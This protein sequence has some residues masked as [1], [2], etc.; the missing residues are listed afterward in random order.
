MTA[1]ERM[2]VI[3]FAV[4]VFV[5][6]GGFLVHVMFYKPYSDL[7]NRIETDRAEISKRQNELQAEKAQVAR[8]LAVDPRM[9][10]WP[11]LS[12][13]ESPS[14]DPEQVVRIFEDNRLACDRDLDA[15]FK[16]CGFATWTTVGKQIEDKTIPQLANKVPVFKRH[17]FTVKAT[18][19]YK[20]IVKMFEQFYREE[21]L[22]HIRD[23]KITRPITTTQGRDR[24]ILDIT[25]TVE[26]LQVT[27]AETTEVRKTR[28]E[29]EKK[30]KDQL[31]A[32]NASA[33][34]DSED[35]PVVPTPTVAAAKASLTSI[36]GKGRVYDPDMV[37]KNIF[38]GDTARDRLTEDPRVVLSGVKLVQVD[39]T[40][41]GWYVELLDQGRMKYLGIGGKIW[42]ESN[43]KN[44]FKVVDRYDNPVLEAKVVDAN[45]YGIVLE[46]KGKFYRMRMGELLQEVLHPEKDGDQYKD[47]LRKP[48]TTYK[49]GDWKGPLAPETPP[50]AATAMTEKDKKEEKEE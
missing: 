28:L 3:I 47:P 46:Y 9:K 5:F 44:D 34:P 49:A 50:E 11:E 24:S 27:G 33:D 18:A 16:R 19:N 1:R 43:A 38:Q 39:H 22:Q 6:G 31:A 25:M 41:K 20:A 32:K 45:G 21:K 42:P 29:K 35:G 23:F 10:R 36:L 8:V 12:L 15:L 13:P 30:E 2:M 4:V 17:S 40:D 37:T 7:R 48:L 26:V 14:R